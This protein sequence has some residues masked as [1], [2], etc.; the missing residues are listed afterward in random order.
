MTYS[1]NDNA[2]CGTA[3]ATSDL[4]NSVHVL[5]MFEYILGTFIDVSAFKKN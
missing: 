1:P 3:P 4:L 2:V 5:V